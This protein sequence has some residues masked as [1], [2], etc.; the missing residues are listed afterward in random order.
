ML[1][2]LQETR[3]LIVGLILLDLHS[4]LLLSDQLMLLCIHKLITLISNPFGYNLGIIQEQVLIEA[5]L[6]L[7]EFLQWVSKKFVS[8]QLV[9]RD[10]LLINR[11]VSYFTEDVRFEVVEYLLLILLLLEVG[12]Y[13]LKESEIGLILNLY[14][15]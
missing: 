11:I 8:K 12:I 13:V 2:S 15:E 5:R 1:L 10:I 4:Q 3:T 7:F 14:L 9:V 6:Q